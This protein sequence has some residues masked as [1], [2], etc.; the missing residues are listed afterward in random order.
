[1]MITAEKIPKDLSERFAKCF[2][3]RVGL[4]GPEL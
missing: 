4:Y 2:V 3:S 1:M